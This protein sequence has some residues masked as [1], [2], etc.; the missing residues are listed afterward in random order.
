MACRYVY[1]Y[2]DPVFQRPPKDIRPDAFPQKVGAAASAALRRELASWKAAVADNNWSNASVAG[3]AM[4]NTCGH[5]G[6]YPGA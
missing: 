1:W 3:F 4:A 5:L 2:Y 6:L